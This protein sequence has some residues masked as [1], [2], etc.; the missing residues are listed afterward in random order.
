MEESREADVKN[1]NTLRVPPPILAGLYLSAALG[2]H[3]LFPD[4]TITPP[5]YRFLGIAILGTGIFLTGWAFRLC[6]KKGT[7]RNPYGTPTAVVATGPFRFGRNPMYL[8]VSVVLLGVAIFVGTVPVFLAPVAF[9]LTMNAVFIPREERTLERLF[10]Q[11]YLDYKH[12]VR[13]W[14]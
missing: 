11:E 5:R 10:G 14:L 12:R 2:L 7:T 6:K 8:G 3:F 1:M 13:R 9:F 4:T